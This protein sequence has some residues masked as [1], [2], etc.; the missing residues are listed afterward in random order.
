VAIE[1]LRVLKAL[2]L[3]TRRTVRLALWT[4]SEQ[5]L[6][7]SRFYVAA[8]FADPTVMQLKPQHAQ[9]SA[10]INLDDGRG[11]LRG[12][13]VQGNEGAARALEPWLAAVKERGV[14]TVSPAATSNSDHAAFDAV[15]LPAFDV[16][17]E[18][19]DA[20]SPRH[21]SAD[22]FDRLVRD[23]LVNNAALVAS[24]IYYV[25]NHE[26]LMPRKPLPKPDP[27]AAG[28]W[29]PGR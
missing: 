20:A 4:G 9:L 12:I 6:L 1:A 26:A 21:S 27:K 5:G 15:G 7:G 17:Q 29:S 13:R 16:V 10:Y 25:A 14:S 19:V 8:H 22:T 11:A 28:P 18:A 23:D 24:L 2:K 3:E